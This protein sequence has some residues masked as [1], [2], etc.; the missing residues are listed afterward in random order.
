[1]LALM[2][3]RFLYFK[4]DHLSLVCEIV[5]PI[6]LILIG[7]SM[8]KIKFLKDPHD[9]NF[10]RTTYTDIYKI[11]KVSNNGQDITDDIL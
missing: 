11:N 3:K 9:F 10:D 2:K 8:T 6:I 4:R 1:M 5:I 7:L